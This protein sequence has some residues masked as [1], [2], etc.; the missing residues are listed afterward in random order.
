[1]VSAYAPGRIELLGNHTDYNEGYALA[2]AVNMGVTIEGEPHDDE[3]AVLHI[4]GSGDESFPIRGIT[5]NPRAPWADLCKGVVDQMIKAGAPLRGFEVTVTNAMPEDAALGASGATAAALVLFLQK[6]FEFEFGDTNDPTIR[7]GLAG[8]CQTA[9]NDFVGTRS[10]IFDPAVSIMGR[11]D[12]AV[13]LDFRAN[14]A[15]LLAL[16]PDICFVVCHAGVKP[17][18]LSSKFSARRSECAEAVKL[19]QMAKIDVKA[20]RDIK[21][22]DVRNNAG[23]FLPRVFQ[24][25]MHVTTEN[26]RVLQARDAIL[27]MDGTDIE[28]LGKL[29]SDSQESSRDAFENSTPALDQLIAVAKELPACLGARLTGGGF[30]GC[31]LNMVNR[32]DAEAFAAELTRQYREKSGKEPTAWIVEASDG[33]V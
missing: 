25:A 6:A 12:H 7:M 11:K 3:T 33:A 20:L 5:K 16:H 9:E 26:E 22:E 14:S 32:T 19:L 18:L 10:S 27:R 21:S 31:T 4:A 13:F 1:M 28:T 15:E 30:G 29:M 24:R 8:L 2:F 23:L 17:M